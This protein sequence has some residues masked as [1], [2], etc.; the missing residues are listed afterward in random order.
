MRLSQLLPGETLQWKIP[1]AVVLLSL[2]ATFVVDD[3]SL[4]MM[5]QRNEVLSG[6]LWRLVTAHLVHTGLWHWLI[7]ITVFVILWSVFGENWLHWRGILLM[8]FLAIV[9]SGG[10]IVLHPE[11]QW[12]AGLS[13]ILHGLL[14]AGALQKVLAG[15][16]AYLTL[17]VI[18]FIKLIVEQWFGYFPLSD[19]LLAVPVIIDAHLY[20]AVAGLIAA[21]Y[22]NKELSRQDI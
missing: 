9:I 17:L 2:L 8:V 13:G 3:L 10:L 12:Y 18:L 1:G 7:N 20:G 21:S 5:Y 4:M 22:M 6:E 16:R 14:A 19:G 15:Q 11:L